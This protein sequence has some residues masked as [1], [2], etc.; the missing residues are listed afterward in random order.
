MV[1]FLSGPTITAAANLQSLLFGNSVVDG[2]IYLIKKFR[3]TSPDKVTPLKEGMV[4]LQYGDETVD[5]SVESLK[6]LQSLPV[7]DSLQKIIEE[8][9]KMDGIEVFE[10]RSGGKTTETV[11]REE[12]VYFAKPSMP[13]EILVDDHRRA[14]FSIMAL[15]FKDDNKWRL[16]N[17]EQTISAKIEDADF[18]RRVNENEVS[19]SKGDILI[20]YLHVI[21][22]R[23]DTGIKTDYIV[24]KVIDHKPGTR[25][26]PFIF[27]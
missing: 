27:E 3:G 14:A 13:D 9:L 15:A 1:A 19:F 12:S 22:K 18:L 23:T 8:P 25:Q 7:R 26:I 10:V 4:R 6:L 5:I 17:G 16:S 24:D 20:C 21:Q 2:V 11:T